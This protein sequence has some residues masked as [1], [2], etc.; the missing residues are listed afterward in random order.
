MIIDP[1]VKSH[2]V[3]ENLNSAID[4]VVQVL[5]DLTAKYNIAVDVPHHVSKG[6]ADPGNANRGRGASAMKDGGRLIFTL[7]PM[8]TEEAEAFGISDELRGY[9]VRMD[10]AKV[11]IAPPKRGAKWFRLVGVPLGNETEIYPNGD[12]VQTIEPWQPPNTWADVNDLLQ[13]Q[14]I[15]AIDKGLPNGSRYTDA[16]RVEARAAWKIVV[17]HAPGKT[18][19]QAREIIQAWVRNGALERYQYDDPTIRKPATGLKKG[20]KESQVWGCHLSLRN[21][22]ISIAHQLSRFFCAIKPWCEQKPIAHLAR[23]WIFSNAHQLRK[24]RKLPSGRVAA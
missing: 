4:D 14:I 7:S 19:Q 16:P 21:W 17:E 13:D 10:S 18:K 8:S 15:A 24:L 20:T 12:E 23:N 3:E 2:S 5:T 1:F 22:S 11:N 9:Y 6:P